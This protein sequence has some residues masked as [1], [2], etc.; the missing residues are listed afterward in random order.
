M[1]LINKAFS[2][3]ADMHRNQKRKYS[4]LPYI[5]HPFAVARTVESFGYRP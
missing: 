4:G 5:V 1:N 3:A 2:Y